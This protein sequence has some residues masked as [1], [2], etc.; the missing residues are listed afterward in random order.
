LELPND[1]YS[2]ARERRPSEERREDETE[3]GVVILEL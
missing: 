1:P 3:R 2:P